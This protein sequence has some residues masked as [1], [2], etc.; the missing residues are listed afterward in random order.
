MEL[1]IP[2]IPTIPTVAIEGGTAMPIR[3]T[4]GRLIEGILSG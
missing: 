4:F 1:N 3:M 2:S